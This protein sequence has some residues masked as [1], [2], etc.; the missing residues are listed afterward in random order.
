MT[1]NLSIAIKLNNVK[2]SSKFY[3][4]GQL[5]NGVLDHA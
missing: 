1:V 3:S 5:P 4:L 2:K